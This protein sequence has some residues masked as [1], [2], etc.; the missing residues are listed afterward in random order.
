VTG[1]FEHLQRERDAFELF[2][3]AYRARFPAGAGWPLPVVPLGVPAPEL[4]V[5]AD[6]DVASSALLFVALDT[7][8]L[9]SP[10]EGVFAEIE[11]L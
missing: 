3:E 11:W 4:A 1:M 9:V 8:L 5:G 2:K 6:A 10:D 7:I